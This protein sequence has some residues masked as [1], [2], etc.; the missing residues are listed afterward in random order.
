MIERYKAAKR[1]LVGCVMTMAL[2]GIAW[3][4]YVPRDNYY[5][6]QIHLDRIGM[7]ELWERCPKMGKGVTVAVLD[8]GADI[9][10]P[11]LAE[12]LWHNP[13]EIPNNNVDD[14]D[15]GYVDDVWGLN[16]MDGTGNIYDS[17]AH[18]TCVAT[19]IAARHDAEGCAGIAPKCTLLPIKVIDA[20]GDVS[21]DAV[22]RAV[23]TLISMKKHGEPIRIVQCSWGLLG[24]PSERLRTSFEKL[25][26]AGIITVL[27][28]GNDGVR[29]TKNSMFYPA[30]FDL[31]NSIV[32]GSVQTLKSGKRAPDSNYG[33]VVDVYAPGHWLFTSGPQWGDR[34]PYSLELGDPHRIQ[35]V[36]GTSFAAPQVAGVLALLLAEDY[37]TD[38]ALKQ[39]QSGMDVQ[40]LDAPEL[41]LGTSKAE[42][43]AFFERHEDLDEVKDI[44][45]AG[46]CFVTQCP[47]RA[48][49]LLAPLFI[50]RR[51][52]K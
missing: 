13:L 9:S 7:P 44:T 37:S 40:G 35:Y 32:V 41:W 21:I 26:D 14:D 20:S 8:T 47:L 39:V 48:L 36:H 45:P 4:A 30:G 15:N 11:D 19:I 25:D 12:S 27:I 33:D 50:L 46:G 49:A 3:G 23:D 18:G 42:Y 28:A 31:V 38:Q 6:N 5:K 22:V 51:S 2:T 29:L 24:E 16:P 10:V 52:G 43:L 1:C 17:R 34:L